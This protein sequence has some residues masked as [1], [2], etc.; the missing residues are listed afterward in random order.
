VGPGLHVVQGLALQKDEFD[1]ERFTRAALIHLAA[2]GRMDLALPERSS[3]TLS[4]GTGAGPDN[5]LSPAEIR[6]FGL[7][8][9]LV[10]LSRTVVVGDSVAAMGS[11]MPLVSDFLDAGAGSVLASLWPVGEAEAA[12]FAG[13]FYRNLGQQPDIRSA[14]TAT[15][16]SFIVSGA[17]TNFETW[18]G[19]QLFIR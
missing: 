4:G 5:T 7:E 2:P 3:L 1:D 10:V 15:R 11:R 14:F 12:S 13:A 18:A 9:S 17:A 8:A 16:R 19:F 6:N